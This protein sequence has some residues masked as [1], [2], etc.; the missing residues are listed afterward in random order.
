[1]N[2]FFTSLLVGWILR[3]FFSHFS[4]TCEERINSHVEK[5]VRCKKS[6]CKIASQPSI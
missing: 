4:F 5:L 3:E 2:F 1:M 6:Y